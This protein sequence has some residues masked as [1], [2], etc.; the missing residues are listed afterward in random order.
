MV[1]VVEGKVWALRDSSRPGEKLRSKTTYKIDQTFS[2]L[3]DAVEAAKECNKIAEDSLEIWCHRDAMWLEN[4]HRV[5]NTNNNVK[6][7]LAQKVL[8]NLC[9]I[10]ST[11]AYFSDFVV[12]EI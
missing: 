1:Y 7:E 10:H 9:D 5:A 2:N 11:A 8:S 12:R 4:A 6:S 3:N